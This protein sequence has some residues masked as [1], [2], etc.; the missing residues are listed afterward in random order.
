MSEPYVGE[1]RLFA[2]TYAPVNFMICD[3]R[4]LPIANYDVLYALLG[5]VY[6]GD[7]QT[8]FGIP[9]LRGRAPI[10][11]GQG[12]GLPSYQMGQMAGSETVALNALQLGAHSHAVFVSGS[13]GDQQSPVAGKSVLS[14]V[15]PGAPPPISAWQPP[16]ANPQVVLNG[17]MTTPAGGSQPHG[18][19]QPSTAASYIICVSGVFPQHS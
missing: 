4:L 10:H 18:N 8:T 12:S 5:T 17:S 1:I 14:T 15:G 19:L 16:G 13:P 2:G 7:G 3:G 6:G 9:D 11:Q